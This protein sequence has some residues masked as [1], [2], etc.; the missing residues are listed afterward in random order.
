MGEV[1]LT[2]PGRS[3]DGSVGLTAEDAE[4]AEG[5]RF[6]RV[7]LVRGWG[8]GTHCWKRGRIGGPSYTRPSG[9]GE[10]VGAGLAEL[11]RVQLISPDPGAE[12]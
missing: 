4:D 10:T 5:L 3:M 2:D 11:T 6:S 9:D 8:W 1:H 7:R 12:H